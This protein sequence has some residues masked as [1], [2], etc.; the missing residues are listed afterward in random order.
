MSNIL[1]G[2]DETD[3]EWEDFLSQP[4]SALIGQSDTELG[5][6]AP[7][8]FSD[9]YSL[10]MRFIYLLSVAFVLAVGVFALGQIGNEDDLDVTDT[11]EVVPE[12]IEDDATEVE[13]SIEDPVEEAPIEETEVPAADSN[14]LSASSR[15]EFVVQTDDPEGPFW[16]VLDNQELTALWA[17]DCLDSL[18]EPD[19]EIIWDELSQYAEP[20]ASTRCSELVTLIEIGGAGS[21]DAV[22]N[23][24][25]Q[26]DVVGNAATAV[27]P[28]AD[29]VVSTD[30]VED[31]TADAAEVAPP[32]EEVVSAEAV[33]SS[34]TC[35]LYTSPSPRDQ[36]GA[37]MPSSA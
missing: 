35:L 16:Y 26:T 8:G 22:V 24:E 29:E 7:A 1:Q 25:P 17:G 2:P 31:T 32:A 33:E 15:Y 20:L 28:S 36:R 21:G 13:P 34:T 4:M 18:G 30:V 12:V 37:R 5:E 6:N 9:R 14:A 19:R 3:D 10:A 11:D 23:N 27:V